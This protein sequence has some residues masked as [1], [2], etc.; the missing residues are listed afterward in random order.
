MFAMISE[1]SCCFYSST[2]EIE[3]D[4]NSHLVV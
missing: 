2:S 3:L 1:S 4:Y